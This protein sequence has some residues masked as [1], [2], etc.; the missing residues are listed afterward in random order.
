MTGDASIDVVGVHI[1]W[2]IRYGSLEST[3]GAYSV[4]ESS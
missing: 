2:L 3:W 1:E 4:S